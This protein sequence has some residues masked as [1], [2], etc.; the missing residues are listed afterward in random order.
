MAEF[1]EHRLGIRKPEI[2]GVSYGHGS[3]WG[4]VGSRKITAFTNWTLKP[5]AWA[6][7][8]TSPKINRRR[9]LFRHMISRTPL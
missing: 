7:L 4:D 9:G 3:A 5:L 6:A 8:T 1:N 2:F